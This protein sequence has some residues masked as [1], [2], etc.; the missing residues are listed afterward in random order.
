MPTAT[1]EFRAVQEMLDVDMTNISDGQVFK[2]VASTG[3]FI[4]LSAGTSN[5]VNT[6]PIRN[7]S[8]GGMT[9][10]PVTLTNGSSLVTVGRAMSAYNTRPT[11]V[12][13]SNPDTAEFFIS[14]HTVAANAIAVQGDEIEYDLWMFSSCGSNSSHAVL[15]VYVNNTLAF[16]V[17]S[18]SVDSKF[19]LYMRLFYDGSN[20]WTPY[21]IVA[22]AGISTYS[23][24]TNLSG[25]NPTS[26]VSVRV[27]VTVADSPNGS[28]VGSHDSFISIRNYGYVS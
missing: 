12:V 15:K 23:D 10:G 7:G 4:G 8:N 28:D 18:I 11:T 6:L 24:Y 14:V 21:L 17:P 5:V 1:Q 27:S 26:S 20:T 25:I 13:V 22:G 2:Y 3:K 16:T 9:L 19:R